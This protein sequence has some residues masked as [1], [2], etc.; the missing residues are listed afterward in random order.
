MNDD[1]LDDW[2]RLSCIIEVDLEYPEQLH[3]HHN[4]YP[5]ALERVKIGNVEKLIPNAIN[6][7]NYVA[8][9]KIFK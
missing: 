9:Y 1:E 6:K 4:G 3:N 7:I 2:K 5:L 8:H